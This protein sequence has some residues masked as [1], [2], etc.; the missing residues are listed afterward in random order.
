MALQFMKLKIGSENLFIKFQLHT[1]KKRV[2]FVRMLAKKQGYG[3]S[4]NKNLK[5]RSM[6]IN[7]INVSPQVQLSQFNNTKT[8]YLGSLGE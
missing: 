4:D 7:W 8:D 6:I 5:Q 1:F 3:C 2:V